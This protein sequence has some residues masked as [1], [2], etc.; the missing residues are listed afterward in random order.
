MS[1]TNK[2]KLT[3]VPSQKT[4]KRKQYSPQEKVDTLVGTG[5]WMIEVYV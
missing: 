5:P 4:N 1:R 3:V 2:Q